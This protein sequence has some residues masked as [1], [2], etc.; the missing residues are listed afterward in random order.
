MEAALAQEISTEAIWFGAGEEVSI[1]TRHETPA[2]KA[3]SIVTVITAEEIKKSRVP[4]LRGNLK[5]GA[6]I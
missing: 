4:Y 5:D 6:W 1:A 2:G 3:P